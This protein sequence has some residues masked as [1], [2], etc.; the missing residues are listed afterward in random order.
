M[1]CLLEDMSG[2][3]AFSLPGGD[4][5][6]VTLADCRTTMTLFSFLSFGM[7][8]AD[9]DLKVMKLLLWSIL[10]CLTVFLFRPVGDLLVD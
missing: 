8:P 7:R 4:I 2:R 3:T 10:K 9:D 6:W 1:C 5:R